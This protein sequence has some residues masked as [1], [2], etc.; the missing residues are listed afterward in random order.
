MHPFMTYDSVVA[1]EHY[2]ASTVAAEVLRDGGN[3]V[4]ASVVASLALSVL[5]PHLSG[6]GGDFFALVKRGEEIK[7]IDGAGPSPYELSRDELFRRGFNEMPERGPLSI[8]VPG[9]LD[10]LHLMW[11]LYGSMEWSSLVSRVVKLA[12]KGF[13]VSKSLSEAVK[14]NRELLSSDEG[15]SSTYL[16]IGA[17]GSRHNFKGLARAL[18]IISEDPREFYEG[19]IAQKIVSYVRKRGGLLSI[20]DLSEY[21]AGEGRPISARI[22]GGVAYEMPPPTQGITTLH[23]MMLTE[24]LDGPRSWSRLRKL[25]EISERAYSIRD[26]YLTDPKFMG[27]RVEELLHPSSLEGAAPGRMDDGDTTFFS[28]IDRD[29]MMVAGIQSIFYAF[30]SGVTEPNY[31]ITLNCRASSFSLK[32]DHV[33]RLE[34]GK[35][36]LHTL[37]SLIFELDDDWYVIGTSG[38]HY[39]PQIHWWLS[40]NIFKFGMDLREALDFPRAYF[41]LSKGILVAEEGLE[42]GSGVKVDLRRYPSRLGVAALTCMRG[43]GLRIGCA[44]LRGD[45]GCSGI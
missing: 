20:E 6:L 24:A 3:A 34:P 2:L 37:S 15:S 39:R 18:E 14:S 42:I 8:T 7:F 43:D 26:R 41:D 11:K 9:Y 21:R 17:T 19:E 30:G 45:G 40:T 33:N 16:S 25:I 12:E 38:G 31:Q 32:E 10:A 44:D 23:M 28:V 35:R 5:L 36:T 27:V 29:G 13:P 1:S 22:W 4:D